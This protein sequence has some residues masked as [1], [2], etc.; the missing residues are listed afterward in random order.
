MDYQVQWIN[1]QLADMNYFGLFFGGRLIGRTS[2]FESENLGS[3]PSPQASWKT[4][5]LCILISRKRHDRR[6]AIDSVPEIRLAVFVR[7]C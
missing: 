7:S 5:N 2:D 6:I 3:R 1:L 4:P